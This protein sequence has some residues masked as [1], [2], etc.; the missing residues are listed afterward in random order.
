MQVSKN[1]V[2]LAAA[3]WLAPATAVTAHDLWL[4]P[5]TP[6]PP[7]GAEIK[8]FAQ[9]G[10]EFGASLSAVAPDR[11][12]AF[13]LEDA[14][15]RQALSPA[16]AEEGSLVATTRL[17]HPGV[18]IAALAVRPR[19][20]GLK[21]KEFN[22]YLKEDGLP[23]IL[24]LRKDKGELDRDS[25]EMYAKFAKAIL[26]VGEGGPTTLAT[27]AVGLRIEIV[28]LRDPAS[29]RAGE[30]LPVQVLFEGRP[31]P[32]VYVYA[33][34]KGESKYREGH[35]TEVEGKTTVPLP[36]AGLMSLH[37]IF[38]RPHPD[39]SKY[40]WE[41][42]FATLTFEAGSGASPSSP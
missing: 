2:I 27:K 19:F 36:R 39:A 3:A 34:A 40:D 12:E 6:S 35:L 31:L 13:F 11:I 26:R 17:E 23:Q 5:A 9:T 16:G 38:M 4:V 7:L 20:L 10:M 22:E 30:P 32:G 28:P 42:F 24:G 8:L 25:R 33:L 1:L 29:L 21:A 37:T 18:A 14:G 41:S 15:G